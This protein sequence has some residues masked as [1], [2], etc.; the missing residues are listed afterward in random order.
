MQTARGK[1]HAEPIAHQRLHPIAAPI[2]KHV[3]V[4]RLR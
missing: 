2:Q 1:P 3:R 4:V